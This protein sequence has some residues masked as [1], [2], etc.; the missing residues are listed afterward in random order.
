MSTFPLMEKHF[1]ASLCMSFI[2]L[3][4]GRSFTMNGQSQSVIQDTIFLEDVSVSVLPFNE[5][6][7][8]STGS[9]F[10]IASASA[11][12][13]QTINAADLLNMAPGIHMASGT[14]NTNRLVIRG[15]GSRTPYGTNRIRA[16]LDDIPL[17]SGDG[18]S[19]LEDIDLLGIGNME[20]LKG[21]SSAL[22]GSGLGGIV[23]LHSPY[24]SRNGFSATFLGEAGSFQTSRFGFKVN[25]KNQKIAAVGGVASSRSDGFRENSDYSRTN[26]FLSTRFFGKRQTFTLTL[27]MVDL[28]ALIPSSLNEADFLTNPSGAAPNWLAVEGFEAYLKILGGLKV[29][30]RLNKL[31][32][33]HMVL[34]TSFSD[35]YESRP[36]NILD[37][38]T[39]NLGLREYLQVE[40]GSV[41]IR[42][43]FELFHEWYNW[44]IFETLQGERGALQ[45]DQNEK[46]QYVNGFALVQW[47]PSAGLVIDGGIN[48]NRLNYSLQTVFQSDSSDQSGGYSYPLIPSPRIG[49]SYKYQDQHHFYASAGHGFSA[50]SLEETLLPEGV[51]NT[52]LKPETGWNLEVG[53]RGQFGQGRIFYDFTIYAILLDN[54]LVTKRITEDI[55]TGANAGKALNKGMEVLVRGSLFP[56]NMERRSNLNGSVGFTLSSNHF[57]DFIDDG[58]DYG[59]NLL[60]GIPSRKLNAYLRAQFAPFN[61]MLN[62]QNTGRQWMDDANAMSYDPYQLVHMHLSWQYVFSTQPFSIELNGGIRNL[63]NKQYAS[64]ILVNAPAFGGNPPRY[65]YPGQPRHFHLGIIFTFR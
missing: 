61:L 59:G 45:S 4:T 21:P 60:P 25:Y 58:I 46:R 10:S 53:N 32:T 16:Y 38:Q 41:N 27:S 31:F 63:F 47:R 30:S 1:V 64:M 50:P 26:A 5:T 44:K 9:I 3:F 42:A 34:F 6:Y 43:G 40:K 36:F 33:N 13:G 65:F 52:E 23:R 20:I 15:I 28:T 29:E 19:T 48:L 39:A 22:Y 51:V 35:P 17:T 62:Y 14:Y 8:E 12:L 18:V 56:E 49:L 2:L 57:T 24:P 7:G 55:F 54:L 11:D 37:E